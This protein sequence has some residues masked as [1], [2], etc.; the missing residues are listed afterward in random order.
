MRPGH[1]RDRQPRLAGSWWA[2]REAWNHAMPAT[3]AEGPPV[4]LSLAEKAVCKVVYG[5][6]RPRPLLLP[7]GLEL[8]LYAQKMRDLQKKR[9]A[10]CQRG[11]GWVLEAKGPWGAPGLSRGGGAP[12]LRPVQ[13][14]SSRSW[15]R[16]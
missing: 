14:A 8:W 1:P 2:R 11:R 5:A 9:C 3:S 6:P 12:C 10:G 16:G 13:G 15:S 7:V 4:A